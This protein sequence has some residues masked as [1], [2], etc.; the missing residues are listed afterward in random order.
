MSLRIATYNVHGGVG[1]DRRYD[2]DRIAR[3]IVELDAEVIGLQELQS[4]GND[5]M[6]EI[7]QRATSMSAIAATTFRSKFGDFGNGLL[8]R[9]PIVARGCIDLNFGRREP[10]NAIDATLD[11][12]GTPLQIICTHL[13][14]R[15]SER[16]EQLRRLIAAIGQRP[17]IPT[18]LMGDINDWSPSHRIDRALHEHFGKSPARGTFPSLFPLL[19]LDRL[20]VTPPSTLTRVSAH[21]SRIARLASDHLPLIA[22][23]ELRP[24]E[25]SHTK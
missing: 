21:R 12:H 18:V 4:H 10:R 11:C 6:L 7:L 14:L 2:I 8:T 9:L 3:V 24:P 1:L 19:A 5:N 25:P 20:W 23:L 17:E 15:A 16:R 13:G 22:Q